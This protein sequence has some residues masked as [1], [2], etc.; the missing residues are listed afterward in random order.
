MTDKKETVSHPDHYNNNPSGVEAIDV[1]EHMPFNLGN[2][3]KYVWRC[4]DKGKDIEDLE[5]AE[6]YLQREIALRKKK[7]KKGQIKC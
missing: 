1:I 2:V 4:D 6:F 5:K 7:M 3:M